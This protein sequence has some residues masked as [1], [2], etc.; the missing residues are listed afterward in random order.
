MKLKWHFFLDFIRHRKFVMHIEDYGCHDE[1]I[2]HY[3]KERKT[4]EAYL[5]AWA[6]KALLGVIR[7][8]GGRPDTWDHP[9]SGCC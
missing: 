1:R 7:G 5:K 6:W 4:N 8:D 3:A 9:G 2:L